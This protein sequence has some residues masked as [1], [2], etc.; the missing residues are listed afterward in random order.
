[1]RRPVR[2]PGLL[3]ALGLVAVL[4]AA[5]PAAAQTSHS[6]SGGEQIPLVKGQSETR[7]V[8]ITVD[9]DGSRTAHVDVTFSTDSSWLTLSPTSADADIPPG[10]SE[11]FSTTV[12]IDG[13][14]PAGIHTVEVT[15]DSNLTADSPDGSGSADF[16]VLHPVDLNIESAS[17][18]D[19]AQGK[20]HTITVSAGEQYGWQS[21]DLNSVTSLTCKGPDQNTIDWNQDF[22]LD[23]STVPAGDFVDIGTLT[24]DVPT[25]LDAKKWAFEEARCTVTLDTSEG[26]RDGN[27][28]LDPNVPPSLTLTVQQ[29]PSFLFDEPYEAKDTYKKSVDVQVTNHGESDWSETVSLTDGSGV[30][31]ESNGTVDISRPGSD[32]FPAVLKVSKDTPE[33][34]RNATLSSPSVPLYEEP[35]VS[36][37]VRYDA[38]LQAEGKVDL[39]RVLVGSSRARNISLS[40]KLGHAPVDLSTDVTQT[41]GNAS[42]DL[43]L[44]E[45][46]TVPAGDAE[47]VPLAFHPPAGTPSGCTLKWEITWTPEDDRPSLE[48]RTTTVTAETH[49]DKV[50]QAKTAL[51]RLGVPDGAEARSLLEDAKENCGLSARDRQAVVG[52]LQSSLSLSSI[53][54]TLEGG[55]PDP[56]TLL[57]L[58]V[59]WRAASNLLEGDHPGLQDLHPARSAIRARLV[60]E[61]QEE[62]HRL[63]KSED[64]PTAQSVDRVAT[65]SLALSTLGADTSEAEQLRKARLQELRGRY[66]EAQR[67][68]RDLFETR[69][70][71]PQ[72][73]SVT[74]GLSVNPNPLHW[75][76]VDNLR[77]EANTSAAKATAVFGPLGPLG[78]RVR[79]AE[80]EAYK[81]LSRSEAALKAGGAVDA[82]VAL[83]VVGY[84][85]LCTARY[86]RDAREVALGS[87]LFV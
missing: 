4:L 41:G 69:L 24:V 18:S 35:T 36:F 73:L 67:S 70:K 87:D 60:D 50:S 9:N 3:A 47:S 59:R 5:V 76:T 74:A 85:T 54:R 17:G 14:T 68:L 16:D 11:T 82:A 40:E 43:R 51:D 57:S 29:S 10:G 15:Y 27:I 19:L 78:E 34:S 25:G 20:T 63:K 33:G 32:E 30:R 48:P 83:A 77:E 55:D 1:M 72:G 44:R 26:D 23:R 6:V 71:A 53:N 37:D 56:N 21:V 62:L 66:D 58:A 86:I 45:D 80:E 81:A 12:T 2:R 8:S 49:L 64:P 39:G 75:V 84:A 46:V 13:Q 79:F 7:Q 65:V 42:F 31:L 52:V 61:L 22:S 28:D 38:V